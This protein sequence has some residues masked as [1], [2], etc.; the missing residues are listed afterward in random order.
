[1][2]DNSSHIKLVVEKLLPR[3]KSYVADGERRLAAQEARVADLER[4]GRDSP[5]S[6]RLLEIMKETMTLQISHLKLLERE[7][8]AELG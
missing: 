6:K 8:A 7:V 4:S 5:E 3:A 2:A 1:L